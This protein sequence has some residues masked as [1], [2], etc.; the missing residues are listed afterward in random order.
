M[1]RATLLMALAFA[2][3]GTTA[4]FAAD[5]TGQEKIQS[6]IDIAFGA[7][8]TS[9]YISRGL[10]NSNDKPALQGYLEASYN[11]G[12]VGVWASNVD[13]GDANKAEIDIYG[14][15]RPTFGLLNLDIG[16][17]R[18]FYNA[19][20]NCCGEAYVKYDFD[21]TDFVS[22]GGEIY[23]DFDAKATYV[24]GKASI[25]L[26]QDFTLDGGFGT[27]TNSSLKDWDIGLSRSFADMFTA[28]VR[29]HGYN[30]SVETKHKFAAT[31]SLDTSLSALT[32]K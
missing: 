14:G 19:D 13:F 29:Y 8:I 20:G 27:Y 6:A 24:R 15:I 23:R 32:G 3:S 22:L 2:S 1:I 7:S 12:Y 25:S 18:Y 17:A 11:I 28:S 30:D 21:L 31:L 16:Y 4:A 9:N 10:T 5:T 26:P